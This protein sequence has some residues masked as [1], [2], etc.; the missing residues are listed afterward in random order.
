VRVGC[1]PRQVEAALFEALAEWSDRVDAD[2]ALLERP[3]RVVVPSRSLRD[4]VTVAAVRALGKPLVGVSVQTLFTTALELLERANESVRTGRELYSLVVRRE[5]QRE[6]SLKAPLGALVDAHRVVEASVNDLL[7]A[8]FGPEHEQPLCDALDE[9]E[10]EGAWAERARAVA[11]IALAA[12]DQLADAGLSHRAQLLERAREVL[13]SDPALLPA[14]EVWIHGFAEATGRATDL[15]L[16]VA[17]AC[18]TTLLVDEPPEPGAPDTADSGAVFAQRLRE[19]FEALGGPGLAVAAGTPAASQPELLAAPGAEA[20]VRAVAGRIRALLD[21]DP[22]L[23]AERI[24]IVGRQVGPYA[25]ALRAHLGRLGIPYSGVAASVAAG[26]SA[27]RADGLAALLEEA[28]GVGADRWVDVLQG[29]PDGSDDASLRADLRLGL[30]H[31]GAG[32]LGDVARLE[33]PEADLK[34]PVRRGLRAP[35]EDTAETTENEKDARLGPTARYRELGSDVL[36]AAIERARSLCERLANAPDTSTPKRWDAWLRALLVEDLGWLECDADAPVAGGLAHALPSDLVLTRSEAFALFAEHLQN[37]AA[38]E[39][40]GGEGGGVAVLGVMEA[41]ARTFDHLF[42]LGLNR[43]VFPRAIREDPLLPDALRRP[44]LALLPDLPIKATGHDEERYLFAQLAASS[45]ETVLSWQ[46][47]SDNGRERV[48]STFIDRL[49]GRLP[50]L[51]STPV[52]AL[53]DPVQL[54]APGR[55]TARELAIWA[56]VGAGPAEYEARIPDALR[57]AGVGAGVPDGDL[58]RLSHARTACVREYS[59]FATHPGS[60]GPYMGLLGPVSDSADLRGGPRYVTSLENMARC[61]WKA[62]LEKLLRLEAP[63][64]PLESFPELDALIVGSTVHHVLE[65]LFSPGPGD[66]VSRQLTDVRD[67]EPR[68]VEWPDASVI[69]QL[70]ERCARDQLAAQGFPYAGLVRVLAERVAAH[71]ERA[72]ELWDSRTVEVLGAEVDGSLEVADGER[73]HTLFFRADLVERAGDI[74]RLSDYKTGKPVSDGK[75]A[76]TR[77]GHFLRA[78]AQ[79]RLLQAVAYALASGGERDIGR[80]LFLGR[81]LRPELAEVAFDP[82]AP[83]GAMFEAAFRDAVSTLGCSWDAGVFP[84]RLTEVATDKSAASCTW[85]EL[86]S[87]CLQGDTGMRK[88]QRDWADRAR[89]SREEGTLSEVEARYLEVWELPTADGAADQGEGAS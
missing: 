46:S 56:G 51:E 62:V 31:L 40:I 19:R 17:G 78:V 12:R 74:V 81:D 49:R 57:D 85:C 47:S 58:A 45:L 79:G 22:P 35:E 65:R 89:I 44:L 32:R 2:L 15:L 71:V 36:N 61:P 33:A 29:L 69:A 77:A 72:R 26:A 14:S 55:S 87:A 28:E 13:E 70:A 66:R 50:E 86:S 4:H 59:R 76:A 48:R 63:P 25:H 24:A 43:E 5:L 83:Q 82:G 60:L 7:D 42:V 18:G 1:G 68:V 84:P 23:A 3:L 21:A 34:L 39:P 80:Y 52:P 20:E 11:R 6:P 27:R 30:R 41:R 38:R 67:A 64:D 8:G 10:S 54:S 16:A 88:R 37:A 73:R 53:Y 9:F 75:K